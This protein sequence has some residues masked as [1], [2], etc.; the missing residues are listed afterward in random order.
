MS[1]EGSLEESHSQG[2][3]EPPRTAGKCATLNE[4]SKETSIKQCLQF[5][6]Y[7]DRCTVEI[8]T[9][10]SPENGTQHTNSQQKD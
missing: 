9:H 7:N 3:Y 6:P 1:I 2:T 5:K 8:S 4:E 10:S